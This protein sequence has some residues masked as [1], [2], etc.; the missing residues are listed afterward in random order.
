[1]K[2]D[3]SYLID[4]ETHICI[5]KLGHH[6][7]RKWLV[8]SSV[9]SHYLNQ[10]WII[11][12]WMHGNIFQWNLNHN[13]T[14]FITKSIFENVV[15]KMLAIWSWPQCVKL[16]YMNCGSATQ[17]G[18]VSQIRVNNGMHNG[19]QSDST[20]PLPD[21][22]LTE[23]LATQIR[24]CG[25]WFNLLTHWGQDK[26]ADIMQTTFSNAL[27]WMKIYDFRLTYH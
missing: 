5:T 27:S 18:I 12:N 17:H 25:G 13:K 4:A 3:I 19:L 10:C 22:M 26:M 7:F 2:Y 21:S 1:M 8:T 20:W 24:G 11:V 16:N 15:F 23:D 6:W 9:P 14:L